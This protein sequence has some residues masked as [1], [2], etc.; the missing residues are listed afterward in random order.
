MCMGWLLPSGFLGELE[1]HDL[2]PLA[3]GEAKVDVC[4]ELDLNGQMSVGAQVWADLAIGHNCMGRRSGPT[5]LEAITA[6]AAGLGRLLLVSVL[7]PAMATLD[8]C[9]SATFQLYLC[10]K[11]HAH[12]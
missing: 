9:T 1:M 3:V 11:G 8:V 12:G 2:R 4:I 7:F 5:W 10:K 6:W